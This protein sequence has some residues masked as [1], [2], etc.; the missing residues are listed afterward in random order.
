L[1][2]VLVLFAAGIIAGCTGT[3]SAPRGRDSEDDVTLTFHLALNPRVYEDSLWA[4]PPQLAIWLVNE[5]DASI[6]TVRVTHRTGAGDWVGKVECGVALPYW[7]SFYNRQTETQGPPTWEHP[8]VDAIT[9]ATPRAELTAGVEVLR[10]SRWTYYV[11]INVSGDFNAAFPRMS[12]EAGADRYGNGQPSL[13]YKGHIDA[14][15]GATSRPQ[16][17]GRTDQYEPVDQITTDLTGITTARELLREVV[18][19]CTDGN[20]G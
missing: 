13:V 2:G 1:S 20:S 10:G 7:T 11:E 6:R 14:V 16:L 3:S 17:V 5:A 12:E 19:S 9:C 4:D 8:A 18:V 15:N